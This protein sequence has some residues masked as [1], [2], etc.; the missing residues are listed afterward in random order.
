MVWT[1]ISR[2]ILSVSANA[3]Q[4]RLL[5]RGVRTTPMWLATYFLMLLPAVALCFGQTF[6]QSS[7]FWSNALLAGLLDAAGNLAMVAALR[8]IDLSLFGPLNAFRPA[9]ALLFGWLFLREVPTLVGGAGVI[10]TVAGAL[11]LFGKPRLGQTN[12]REIWEVLGLRFGGL[13]LSTVGA[14]FLKRAALAGSAELTLSAWLICGLACL[15]VATFARKQSPLGVIRSN[16]R[17]HAIPIAAHAGLFLVMQW[18]TIRIFQH[19]LLSYS[20][21]YF[22]LGMVLQVLVGGVLFREPDIGRRLIACA[23]MCVGS[24]LVLWKG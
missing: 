5:L 14:V 16:L 23:I 10:I 4:K 9:L 15:I 20:F 13:A 3:L 11:V 12:L 8:G 19:T 24:G 17:E 2:V 21:V 1:I 22:Q 6:N 18:L 7:F